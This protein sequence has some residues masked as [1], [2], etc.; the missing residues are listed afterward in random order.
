[1][2][3][4][5]KLAKYKVLIAIC[6]ALPPVRNAVAHPCDETSLAGARSRQPNEDHQ[7]L[8][9]VGYCHETGDDLGIEC[10]PIS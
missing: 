8:S 3:E 4:P 1:M 6:H 2:A 10:D 5:R 7:A 9:C